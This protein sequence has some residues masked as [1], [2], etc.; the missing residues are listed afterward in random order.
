MASIPL[1]ASAVGALKKAIRN[2]CLEVCG[3]KSSHLS[4]AIA[5]ALG[6]RTH[7][8]LLSTLALQQVDSL[9]GLLDEERFVQRLIELGYDVDPD[10]SF[11]FDAGD[12][13]GL[14]RTWCPRSYEIEY[15]TARDNAWRN[16]MVS[17]I[18]EGLERRLFTLR[19]DDNRWPGWKPRGQHGSGHMYDFTLPCD[20]PARA[21]VSDAG[22]GE[23]AIHVAVNPKG[24]G[25]KAFNAG[26][27]A[28]DAFAHSWLERERGAWLQ[29]AETGFRCRRHLMTA[30]ATMDAR[31]HCFGDRGRVIM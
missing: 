12:V 14:L 17:A 4:E 6:F 19:A 1:S 24:D 13:P 16:L 8:A 2:G 27:S 5:A 31:P 26:F 21:Y 20:L 22:F 25:V 29:T 30:L 11:E 23:L 18:N 15:K 28:G 10:F 9:H 3:I 7:A